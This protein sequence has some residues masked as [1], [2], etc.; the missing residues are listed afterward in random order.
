MAIKQQCRAG[1]V[2]LACGFGLVS[3][4]SGLMS[5]DLYLLLL[6]GS[7]CVAVR[8]A[9]GESWQVLSCQPLRRSD[10]PVP[11][12]STI[13]KG[14]DACA[15]SL[16]AV[17]A[18]GLPRKYVCMLVLCKR[19]PFAAVFQEVGA[20]R[21]WRCVVCVC[22]KNVSKGA[23]RGAAGCVCLPRASFS[24]VQACFETS[25]LMCQVLL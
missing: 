19:V 14:R 17:D 15:T 25:V 7:G 21:R 3:S 23:A 6:G 24:G 1:E 9:L 16:Y 4:V 13:Y 10:A 20:T 12:S 2:C 8:L 22:A 18:R 5:C 11:C